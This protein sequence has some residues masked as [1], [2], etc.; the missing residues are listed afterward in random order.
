MT[1]KVIYVV[2]FVLSILLLI[3]SIVYSLNFFGAI[4]SLT[5]CALKC[6]TFCIHSGQQKC[7][8]E[9]SEIENDAKYAENSCYKCECS[10]ENISVSI[11]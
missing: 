9:N 5:I 1:R 7:N 8:E 10:I 4:R 3:G 11:Q 6:I 2:G